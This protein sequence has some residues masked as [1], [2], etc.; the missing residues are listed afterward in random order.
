M[1]P[2]ADFGAF[3]DLGGVD[4]LIHVSELSWERVK[5]V[6]S[7]VQPGQKVKVVVLK[8]DR[9]HR[10][11]GLGTGSSRRP[12]RGTPSMRSTITG[13]SWTGKVTRPMDFG[14]FLVELE[15]LASRD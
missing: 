3:V 5:D 14:Y 8:L 4:G 6:A 2:P 13:K 7:V 10:K 11:V 9:E 15:P 1:R 12:A